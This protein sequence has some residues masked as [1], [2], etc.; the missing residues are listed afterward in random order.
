MPCPNI[1]GD[2][3]DIRRILRFVRDRERGIKPDPAWFRATRETLLM[4]VKNTMPSAETAARQ[5]SLPVFRMIYLRLA[6]AMR[7]PV[8]ATLSISTIA[9]GGS[10]ASVSAA[11][12][13]IPGDALYSVK[14]V[15]EQARLAFTTDPNDKMVLK[16]EFTMRRV[17]E[18]HTIVTTSVDNKDERAA[19]ATEILKRDLDT[20]K[21]QLVD[22]QADSDDTRKAADAAK[23][24][25]KN[26][27]EIVRGLD[28]AK[29][30]LSP[31]VKEKVVAAQVQ[32]ADVGIKALEVLVDA[33]QN[34]GSSVT[35]DDIAQSLNA[36]VEVASSTMAETKALVMASSSTDASLPSN[37][38][39][40]TSSAAALTLTN[41]AA[42]SLGAVSQ[43]VQD[44]K[45]TEAVDM[46]KDATTKSFSAQKQ[47]EQDIALSNASS[48]GAVATDTG[49]SSSTSPTLGSGSSTMNGIAPA[50]ST[51]MTTSTK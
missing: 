19:Q 51:S 29:K 6:R 15:T 1:M 10:I 42:Q 40:A 47:V 50:S 38:A 11:E 21:Q 24:V 32:A 4:Q 9:L 48:S 17:D 3:K 27:M 43:L 49:S 44:N 18:L 36:H 37:G 23:T 28:D 14:L 16:S 46:I 13:A 30:D 34:A 8:I 12:S 39:T 7:A 41:A 31:A 45:I 20:L 35:T 25:D 5:K 33:H 22:A 2:T 26:T